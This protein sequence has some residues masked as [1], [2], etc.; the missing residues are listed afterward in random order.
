MNRGWS[1]RQA[2]ACDVDA[3]AELR[4]ALWPDQDASRHAQDIQ[5]MLGSAT[6]AVAFVALDEADEV[7]GFAE[8]TVRT[9]YVNGTESSPVGFLEGWYVK[10]A[11]RRA[12]VGS[13]L[14][15]EVESWTLRQGC[16]ELASDALLGNGLSFDAHIG[17]GFEETER[18]VCFRKRLGG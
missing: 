9:D 11:A 2:Q 3:W 6:R 8:A 12:G 17:C 15:A 14:V 7:V 5:H 4:Q 10:S 18:V 13:A 16:T 1:T